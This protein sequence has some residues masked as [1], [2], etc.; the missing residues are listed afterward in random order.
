N[1]YTISFNSNGGSSVLP[2]TQEYNTAVTKP[3]DPTKT[4]H[5]FVNWCSDE[6]LLVDY[7]FTTMPGE[8]ITLYAKWSANNY[9]ISFN[10]NGGSLVSSITQAYG[11]TLTPPAAPTKTGHSFGGWYTEAALNNLYEFT[12]MPAENKTLY[13]K[14]TINSY[15]IS[16]N[17]NGGT[18]VT[19]ITENYNE[20]ITQ[21]ADPTK[22]GHTFVGWYS[23]ED[24]TNAYTFPSTMPASDIELYAKWTI[25]NYTITFNSKGGSAVEPITRPYGSPVYEPT[26]PTLTGYVFDGWYTDNTTFNDKYTFP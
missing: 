9:T 1:S 16:F 24:L 11:T 6:H 21:P 14:W 19:A 20:A 7:E 22:T 25:N 17:S 8:N 23:N 5:T 18:S 10:S 3:A 26:P 15:T 2:I 4:G 12:T 13:A